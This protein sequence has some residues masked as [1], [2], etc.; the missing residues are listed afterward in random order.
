MSGPAIAPIWTGGS[1]GASDQ[2]QRVVLRDGGGID[3]LD[4]HGLFPAG[5]L[6]A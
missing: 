2:P 4:T 1:S 5:L 6:L 3:P